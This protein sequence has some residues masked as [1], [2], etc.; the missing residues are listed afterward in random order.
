MRSERDIRM[1]ATF[2]T[3][4]FSST[5]LKPK[6]LPTLSLMADRK[7]LMSNGSPPFGWMIC[8]VFLLIEFWDL[9]IHNV[10][11]GSCID[12]CR[13][14]CSK[15]SRSVHQRKDPCKSFFTSFKGKPRLYYVAN[16]MQDYQ[17]EF[18]LPCSAANTRIFG[19]YYCLSDVCQPAESSL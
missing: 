5:G 14:G 8:L 9:G 3:R 12:I 1:I 6:S 17:A 16:H 2:I 4:M 18:R 15:S 7:W 11:L 13:R 10:D 19:I